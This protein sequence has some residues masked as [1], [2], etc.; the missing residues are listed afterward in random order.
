MA[1][2]VR[3]LPKDGGDDK[4]SPEVSAATKAVHEIT[5]KDQK[6]Q[7]ASSQ[8]KGE[9][10]VLP[11]VK[12][13]DLTK[14]AKPADSGEKPI[15]RVA[16][17]KDADALRQATGN[18]NWVARWADRDKIVDL[19]KG[20]TAAELKVLNGIYKMK[21]GKGL[22][23]EMSAFMTGSDRERLKA[24][25]HKKDGNEGTIAAD[26]I[27][28]AL[29]ERG[30][31]TGRSN[32]IIEKD[33]RDSL[34]TANAEQVKQISAEYQ[35]RHGKP[36]AQAIAQDQ[37]LT[38]TTKEAL[39]IYL[40]GND[41]R[42]PEDF[43]KLTAAALKAEDLQFFKEVMKDA[44]PQER[45]AFVANGGDKQMRAA[46]S[47]SDLAQARDFSVDGKLSA[48]T[49][50][51]ENTGT[52]W[53]NNK[54]IEL[55]LSRMTDSERSDYRIG[56]QLSGDNTPL[57]AQDSERLKAMSPAEKA[58][59][60]GQYHTL[61]TSLEAAGNAT[62]LARWESMIN[63]R[64]GSIAATL[65]Q[66][67]GALW[68]D[69]AADIGT[70]I[71][72]MSKKD[73]EA[74]KNNP[75]AR[76]ELEQMLDSLNQSEK[77]KQGLLKIFD[78]KMS[79][80]TYEESVDS[81]KVSVVDRMDEK[82][83]FYRN[84]QGAMLEAVSAMSKE[85][86][87]RYKTDV[88]F[89]TEL[90]QKVDSYMSGQARDEA[91]K[92]LKAVELGEKPVSTIVT[93]LTQYAA[94]AFVD[95]AK[96][97][98]D[99][100]DA[101]NADPT[102]RSRI[103]EPKTDADRAF[104][105]DFKKAGEQ[106]LGKDMYQEYVGEL[107]KTGSISADK[108]TKL[109]K[110][111]FSD[112][113]ETTYEDI[114]KAPKQERDRL[115]NDIAYQNTT[116]DHLN[117]DERKVAL[118]A[119]E[120][121]EYRSEDK[122]RALVLGFGGGRDIVEQLKQVPTEQLN[123]LKS[124][125]ARKYGTSFESDLMAKLSG[126]EMAEAR[127]VLTADKSLVE[128]VDNAR[129][130]SYSTRSG[131]GAG[132][133]DWVSATGKQSDDALDQMLQTAAEANRKGQVASPE[134]MKHMLEDFASAIDNHRETKS[135]AADYTADALIAGGAIASVI[136]TGGT[137]LPLVAALLAAGGAAT[138]VGSKT[139]LMGSDY[140]F[141]LGTVAKDASIGA[142]TG[143]TSVFG[144]AQLAA[145]FKVGQQA[146]KSAATATLGTLAK[147][148][149]E[150]V[151]KRA[152]VELAEGVAGKRL[153]VAGYEKILAEGTETTMRNLLANGARKIEEKSFA[154]IAERVVDAGI[155][156]PLRE[157]AV[158]S[159]RKELTEQATKEFARHTAN[160]LVYQGTAQGLNAGA[161]AA[162]NSGT[163]VL[164]G[165]AA[166][167][168]RK[169]LAGNLSSIGMHT[170]NSSLA[171]AGGALF[172]GGAIKA[173]EAG[174]SG[175]S[176]FK[177]APEVA[178]SE[179]SLAPEVRHGSE[180]RGP[181]IAHDLPLRGQMDF[182]PNMAMA[183]IETHP[184]SGTAA[185]D[186]IWMPAREMEKM[187][188]HERLAL[189][190]E[191]GR[192]I[193]PLNTVA[194]AGQ[195]VDTIEV[196]TKGWTQDFSHLPKA[197]DDAYARFQVNGQKVNALVDKYGM[198]WR[199][200]ELD[201]AEMASSM[202]GHPED[203]ATLKAY[204]TARQAYSD[205]L[206][207]QTKVLDQRVADLQKAIDLF[208]TANNLPSVKVESGRSAAMVG[209]AATYKDGTI[210]LN[211]DNVLAKD[212]TLDLF[213][214]SYH[215]LT[216]HEQ[217][218]TVG[219]SIADELQ[220][221]AKPTKEEVGH[222]KAYYEHKTKQT[223]SEA[224]AQQ[225]LDAR[226]KLSPLEL[227]PEQA[228][229]ASNIEA[230]FRKNAP[231]GEK[232]VELG[233]DFRAVKSY[234]KPFQIGTDPNVA[235][236]L[237]T[238]IFEGNDELLVKRVF[239]TAT[240]SA[241]AQAF[242]G[243]LKNS[244]EGHG[245][246]WTKSE[247]AAASKYLKETLETRLVD[248]NTSRRG[249][250][251]DYMQTHEVD[252][253]LSGQRAR[254]QAMER[255]HKPAPEIQAARRT[256]SEN[257]EIEY[258]LDNSFESLGRHVGQDAPVVK[259]PKLFIEGGQGVVSDYDV[260]TDS[261]T[262]ANASITV[263]RPAA[264]MQSQFNRPNFRDGEELSIRGLTDDLPGLSKVKVVTA[265]SERVS[266][267]Y[268]GPYTVSRQSVPKTNEEIAQLDAFISQ[269]IASKLT[270]PNF[271]APGSA[272][273][274]V[275]VALLTG[276][277]LGAAD[278]SVLNYAL[279]NSTAD[280]EFRPILFTELARRAQEGTLPDRTAALWFNEIG[281]SLKSNPAE[282]AKA[283]KEFLDYTPAGQRDQITKSAEA[284]ELLKRAFNA[285]GDGNSWPIRSVGSAH[286]ATG[287]LPLAVRQL[288]KL[289]DKVLS[290]SEFSQVT[291]AGDKSQ[292]TI[293]HMLNNER[294]GILASL[295]RQQGDKAISADWQVYP[296]V[297]GSPLDRTGADFL[298]VNTKTGDVHFLDATGNQEKLENLSGSN[299]Y[300]LRQSGVIGVKNSLFDESGALRTDADNL[301][302]RTEAINFRPDL[303]DQIWRLTQQ[304]S[305]FRLG[306]D[307]PPLPSLSRTT[308]AEA[309]SQIGQLV[310]WAR[311]KAKTAADGNERS[312]WSDMAT[313]LERA[314]NYSNIQAVQVDSPELGKS[315]DSITRTELINYAMSKF[316]RLDYGMPPRADSV[317]GVSVN[318][319]GTVML[320][321]KEGGFFNGGSIADRIDVARREFLDY[322]RLSKSLSNSQ[323]D[324]LGGDSKALKGLNGTDRHAAIEK[325]LRLN[326]KFQT[327]AKNLA[328]IFMSEQ[329]VI[330][331]GGAVGDKPPVIIKNIE[332][333]LRAR[334]EDSLLGRVQPAV[335]KP[336]SATQP[337]PLARMESLESGVPEST[338][339]LKEWK[340]TPSSLDAPAPNIIEILDL[341]ID[342]NNSIPVAELA[343]FKALRDAYKDPTN[344]EHARAL[345]MIHDLMLGG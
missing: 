253:F 316:K 281:Q 288:D 322:V 309:T 285:V 267:R 71:E 87:E 280:N 201:T 247:A 345:K 277:N 143:A 340:D 88:K 169:G 171:G 286:W 269:R 136:A 287:D 30:E 81:G 103:N 257:A 14:T 227:S 292:L 49:Q 96:A 25:L 167:D 37:N 222:F 304:P 74:A 158:A 62:E 59:A 76:K 48:A 261:I 110:G 150:E 139:V 339:I 149:V 260:T 307:G 327:N 318:K 264:Q 152:G 289:R 310:D 125:Y 104:A 66:H 34:R 154:A 319:E 75:A 31:W 6:A 218:F 254:S 19:L 26:R 238:K 183:A 93:K 13:E 130:E 282:R 206:T 142:L 60:T 306:A 210:T 338:K 252:A 165:V 191:L 12:L 144:Q 78:L 102:L 72:S 163:G 196:A 29:T 52:V 300:R 268:E 274:H 89:K 212:H 341:I 207:M 63:V 11:G 117:G 208:T 216:H 317:S 334:T 333:K 176:R 137:N 198:P 302:T 321:T 236:K 189:V 155:Q 178:R 51:K 215:E 245:D 185:P 119:A 151:A 263:K 90:D 204:I 115:L 344:S 114:A 55:A 86:R 21:F 42:A 248:I 32:S 296:T 39:M 47:G 229:R 106:A 69:S 323:I 228:L 50:V 61:R 251:A 73:W 299:V 36:L 105:A 324:A 56:R 182:T 219:R 58:A 226:S 297:T 147:E 200:G 239:G 132:Y 128:R 283:Y 112:D 127:R 35:E 303:E 265:N 118:A 138:K 290:S 107:L 82:W 259:P 202:K 46:W 162:A 24:A 244:L 298:L 170:F 190:R 240:P 335:V 173:G 284:N 293:W 2:D 272:E 43:T 99:I 329:A 23:E 33:L 148:S 70:S 40:K 342:E 331:G 15:D 294:D 262:F 221:G 278:A 330:R 44:S 79:A 134:Q 131:I 145:V 246:S 193:T 38:A 123:Q 312:D 10:A 111:T 234:L 197:A 271:S 276:D 295:K 164:E 184:R 54:G 211:P 313:V 314:K 279:K 120:Q 237:L 205:A 305:A 100:R 77:D 18:D 7:A 255:G 195:F 266:L 232:L 92:I 22:E 168:S 217:R 156:G 175:L 241:E 315:L 328:S 320:K 64:G 121:G 122:I 68:N 243:K 153:F 141:K 225:L 5:V 186:Q 91:Q 343:K 161:G 291:R 157:A 199:N 256:A 41:K 94:N 3:Q 235:Y 250:Y 17:A 98:R 65:D 108:M 220:L 192:D 275:K 57:G 133:A 166:W 177:A 129:D 337:V 97:V 53:D 135:A 194:K 230:A 308:E 336:N 326:T 4:T 223:M 85:D 83:H 159:V 209:K 179:F 116:L 160:W 180:V 1:I 188:P 45:Q 101:F 140:D 84:D 224:Q 325:Q 270:E 214:S 95:E 242:Y 258:L 301:S 213:E 233:N 20:H 80:K 8:A 113:E 28:V 203:L 174:F 9:S 332:S 16:L 187:S 67:R 172:F 231:A 311:A 126:Q 181:N 27:S 273:A 249:V 124:D 146:A 109:S